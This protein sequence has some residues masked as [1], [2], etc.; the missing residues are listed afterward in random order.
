[1]SFER[2]CYRPCGDARIARRMKRFLEQTGHTKSWTI[3]RMRE[4][5]EYLRVDAPDLW[6]RPLASVINLTNGL[7]DVKTGTLSPHSPCHLSPV[8][9]PVAFDPSATCPLWE[10]FTARVLP[11][12]CQTLPFEVVA[13]AMRGEILDQKAV[14]FVGAGRMENLPC[15]QP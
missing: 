8:Q 3:H 7:L 9:L 11:M 6:D 15:W 14:L 2:G 4:V 10:S 1:M 12:D 5:T 13:S